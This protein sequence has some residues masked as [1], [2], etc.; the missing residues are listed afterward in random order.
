MVEVELRD[1]S[2]AKLE[3]HRKYLD[4][5]YVISGEER[6]GYINVDKCTAAMKFNEEEDYILFD[7]KLDEFSSEEI[8]WVNL[9]EG[10]F[11]VFFPEEAHVPL[12]GKGKI[13][14]VVF[15]ILID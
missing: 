1:I 4:L 12:I 2:E 11:M 3:A 10:N 6:V 5:H 9:K 7:N 15:K 13:K 14:K 8:S